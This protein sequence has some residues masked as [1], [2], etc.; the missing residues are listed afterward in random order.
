M[1]A[2]FQS[3]V[4]DLSLPLLPHVLVSLSLSLSACAGACSACAVS[5]MLMQPLREIACQGVPIRET[6]EER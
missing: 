4:C 6:S 3:L 5:R 2:R 1:C